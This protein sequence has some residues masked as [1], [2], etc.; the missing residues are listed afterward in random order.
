M[1]A[2]GLVLGVVASFCFWGAGA[3]EP[4]DN[5]GE[6]E[7]RFKPDAAL[8]ALRKEQL[9]LYRK[10]V[11]GDAEA[12][13]AW[14]ALK[15]AVRTS[16][17]AELAISKEESP[18]R[19]RCIRELAKLSPGDDP[20][21]L[22][23][24]ALVRVAAAEGDGSLR[25]LARKGL[26]ARDDARVPGWLVHVVERSDE[27]VRANAIAALKEIGTP[28]VFEVIIEHWKETWGASPRDHCFFG[29]VRSYIANYEISGDTYTPVVRSFFT[30]VVL[31][32][33]VLRVEGDVFY[34]TIREVAPED[35]KLPNDP[36][37]WMNWLQQE[38]DKL[39]KLA[40]L[41]KRAA[42]AAL[43]ATDGQ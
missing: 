29:N 4:D 12:S 18:A 31:D 28:R 39:T 37:A 41:K 24:L 1:G 17:L 9:D 16:L 14:E 30:G 7:V 13:K 27:L 36:A 40:E 6:L 2:R 11:A 19:T 5:R 26:A 8:R 21:S 15:P 34:I 32:A 25:A 38:R 3:A 33:K 43:S 42:A 10:A 20:E 35:V 22:A 23:L